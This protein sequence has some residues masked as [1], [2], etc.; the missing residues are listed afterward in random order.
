MF[1]LKSKLNWSGIAT[2]VVLGLLLCTNSYSPLQAAQTDNIRFI[3]WSSSGNLAVAYTSSILILNEDGSILRTLSLPNVVAVRGLEWSPSGD[4]LAY[5]TLP[6]GLYVW[7]QDS[8]ITTSYTVY[9]SAVEG[10]AWSPDGSQI[11]AATTRGRG[12]SST[13]HHIEIWDVLSPQTSTVIYLNIAGCGLTS[14]V[15]NPTNADQIAVGDRSG[16]TL[17]VDVVTETSLHYIKS[18][19]ITVTHS[20][21][22]SVDGQRLAIGG[23]VVQILDTNSWQLLRTIEQGPAKDLNWSIDGRLAIADFTQAVIYDVEQGQILE[24]L[25]GQ[26]HVNAVSWNPSGN[27]IAYGGYNI[28]DSSTGV[29]IISVPPPDAATPAPGD[30]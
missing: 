28:P 16:G 5:A 29:T 1:Q 17:I 19:S 4:Q 22:W 2:L 13:R 7:D 23:D 20:L 11:A 26:Y 6:K 14:I 15:W 12:C 18:P 24:T 3:E 10:V 21:A 25:Q 30:S 27:Q 8:D 9:G